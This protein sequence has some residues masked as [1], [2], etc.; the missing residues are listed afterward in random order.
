MI[1][2]K[3]EICGIN[4]STLKILPEK[5]KQRLLKAINRLNEKQFIVLECLKE[6][7]V[8]QTPGCFH[9]SGPR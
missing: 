4:T 2:N 6:H 5:E 7:Q 3:V 9:A 8:L 1:Y